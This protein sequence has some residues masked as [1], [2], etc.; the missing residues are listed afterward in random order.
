[1]QFTD[2]KYIHIAVQ[3]PPLSVSETLYHLK[4]K[5]CTP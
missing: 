5:L 2:I 4:Q 3:P 1:M